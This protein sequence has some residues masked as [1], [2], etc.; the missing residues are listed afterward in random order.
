MSD[1]I[2]NIY[3]TILDRRDHPS[4]NSYT[5]YLFDQ[6]VDKMLKKVGEETAEVLIAAKNADNRETIGEIADLEEEVLGPC[7]SP[8][9]FDG[10]AGDHASG[11]FRTPE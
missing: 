8:A 6:G 7:L 9:G 3:D 5:R 1:C 10:T 2:Q 11:C 4:E